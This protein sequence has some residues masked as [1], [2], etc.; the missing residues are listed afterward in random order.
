MS[1]V[2]VDPVPAGV[3]IKLDDMLSQSKAQRERLKKLQQRHDN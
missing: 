3:D 2:E 1:V